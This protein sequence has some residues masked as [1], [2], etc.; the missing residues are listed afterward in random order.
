MSIIEKALDKKART[1]GS[2]AHPQSVSEANRD[3]PLI[4]AGLSSFLENQGFK[5]STV[6]FKQ[7]QEELRHIKRP[8]L[9][10]AAG[11][12][13]DV[14]ENGNV[15]MVV[16]AREGEGKT[17]TAISLALSIAM[18]KDKT[19]LLVDVD[20]ERSALSKVFAIDDEPGM[21]DYLL[22]EVGALS[23]VIYSTELSNFKILPA[24][25]NGK[26]SSELFSSANMQGLMKE[27]STRYYDRIVVM[28]LPPLLMT[29][30]SVVLA[31][32]DGQIVMVVESGSKQL[33]VKDAIGL[34]DQSKAIG[35]V[36]NKSRAGSRLYSYGAPAAE[37]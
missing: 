10:T 7:Y 19:V 28:D 15:L 5:L 24:G 36:L 37:S 32:M 13:A 23:D 16:S 26:A 3:K 30:E 8:L 20:T 33:D 17:F 34:L 25:K 9:K 14:I 29:S 6:E 21:V 11:L 4:R 27:I 2:T 12:G 1:G 18:E 35:L 22:G 31:G